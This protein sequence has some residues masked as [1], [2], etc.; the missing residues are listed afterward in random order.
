MGAT[1]AIGA[2]AVGGMAVAASTNSSTATPPAASST[3]SGQAWHSN[4]DA[5]HEQGESAAREA[6]E[7]AGRAGFGH[8]GGWNED[9]AHETSGGAAREAQETAAGPGDPS[10]DSGALA[11]STTAPLGQ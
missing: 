2:S 1:A 7:N 9:P 10:T 6:D 5:T 8:H 3:Q 4:E 11:P